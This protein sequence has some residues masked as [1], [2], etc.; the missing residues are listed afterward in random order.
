MLGTAGHVDHGKTALVKMLTGCDT[1]RLEEEKR[2]G[3]T[4][5]LGFAPC[6]MGDG[7]VVG[8]IDVPGHVDFIRNMVAG[9]H[10]IDVVILVVA[11]DD[12]V[13]PQTR[14]H[15]DI[16][17]ILGVTTGLVALT[18]IDLVD[19]ELREMV[20]QDI[21][22]LLSGTFLADAPICPLSNITGEGFGGFFD[23]LNDRANACPPRQAAGLFRMWVERS[24]GVHGFGLVASGIPAAG[25]V[26]VGDRLR[27]LPA[28][29]SGRIRSME[30]YGAA[31]DEGR[32]GECVALNIADLPSEA[33]ARGSVLTGAEGLEPATMF[34]AQLT[35]LPRLPSPLKDY[36]EVHL[37]VGTAEA[38][39]HVAL[40]SGKL[41]D[42]GQSTAVQFRLNDPVAVAPGERFVIRGPVADGRL[43]TLGGGRVLSASNVRLRRNRPWTSENLARRYAALDNPAQW[44]ATLLRQ[45]DAP[46]MPAA[47]ASE[48]LQPPAQT[49]AWVEQLIASGELL[50]LPGGEVVHRDVVAAA[51]EKL[52]QA[53]KAFHDANPMRDGLEPAALLAAA[54]MAAGLGSLAME[55]LTAA[56]KV[57]RRGAVICLAGRGA[58]VSGEE[59]RLR[60]RV[61]AAL[62]Q[63]HLEPP[64][65][66]DLAASLGIPETRLDRLVQLLADRGE[67]VR[68]DRK[69]VMHR[70]AVDAAVQVVR[71]L[72]SERD[73]FETVEFRDRLGVSRKFAVPLLDY[74][75]TQRLTVRSGNR[76]RRGA[77]LGT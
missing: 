41:L 51:G 71:T 17:T 9:A 28:G 15:L 6:R 42:A 21:S 77:K 61:A 24:F 56:G 25:T 63:A 49:A 27:L 18:K 48:C 16:L 29:L 30:V 54:P 8:V 22:Q 12:G 75:D 72:F 55:T 67:V 19:R 40:L 68:L 47:L 32:A 60:E 7:R 11:A 66:A 70:G 44:C 1:D 64:L 59:D 34:E 58:K 74:F 46:L 26:R 45:A 5:E 38:M 37:H 23:A 36:A 57:Q 52:E 50:K 76:R 14:E 31:T 39:A 43:A 10:G 65:P 53:L 20:C 33:L 62:A 69:V 2:R 4:I 35:L 3:L 73:S 13:M